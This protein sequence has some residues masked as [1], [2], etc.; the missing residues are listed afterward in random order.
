MK[1]DK[2]RQSLESDSNWLALMDSAYAAP[3]YDSYF[4]RHF[5]LA[6]TVWNR[7]KSLPPTTV[8]YGIWQH[9]FPN[10]LTF[11][12]YCDIK[13][14]QSQTAQ[15][16]GDTKR[17]ESTLASLDMFGMRMAEAN[18]SDSD[19]EK[20][21]GLAIARNAQQSHDK[22]LSGIRQGRRCAESCHAP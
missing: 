14:Q 18:A 13:I 21:I 6:R 2:I 5:E 1:I 3:R 20:L 17:A 12:L 19:L 9:G 7:E 22:A 10:M 8:L 16:S 11:R 15:A 4:Q